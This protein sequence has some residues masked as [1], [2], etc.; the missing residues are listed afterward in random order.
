MVGAAD[1]EA[2]KL[3]EAL[4]L[5]LTDNVAL[6]EASALAVTRPEKQLDCDIVELLQA[7]GVK[8]ALAEAER[9][10]EAERVAQLDAVYEAL[11]DACAEK[12]ALGDGSALEERRADEEVDADP[13]TDGLPL[14][15]REPL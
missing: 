6:P 1:A 14:L 13:L 10:P 15:E 4:A 3:L 5:P 9:E 12:E 11:E 2:E 8:K 7:D